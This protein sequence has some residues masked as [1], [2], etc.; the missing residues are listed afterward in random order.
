MSRTWSTFEE[1]RHSMGT[2]VQDIDT[3]IVHVRNPIMRQVFID[4][5]SDHRSP[6]YLYGSLLV[7][8]RCH[9][10]TSPSVETRS[11]AVNLAFDLSDVLQVVRP[12]PLP[13][14]P[15]RAA[16]ASCT[17]KFAPHRAEGAGATVDAREGKAGADV[18]RAIAGA[19][20]KG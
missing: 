13:C 12:Y 20:R 16:G 1:V 18:A 11:H 5:C 9:H 15:P 4:R 3:S 8:D 19:S 2:S 6:P 14:P 10:S 17:V 7:V